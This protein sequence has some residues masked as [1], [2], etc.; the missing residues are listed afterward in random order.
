MKNAARKNPPIRLDQKERT[1][2]CDQ[3]RGLVHLAQCEL[4]TCS[5]DGQR[6]MIDPVVYPGVRIAAA[7]KKR[8][9]RVAFVGG[10][11]ALRRGA[12]DRGRGEGRVGRRSARAGKLP[13]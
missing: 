5:F 13:I 6:L 12:G 1:Q 3:Q 4:A 8:D 9:A 2:S 11:R 10:R 7:W